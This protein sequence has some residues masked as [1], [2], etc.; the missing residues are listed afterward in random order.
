MLEEMSIKNVDII[1]R[2][3]KE[4]QLKNKLLIERTKVDEL[5]FLLKSERDKVAQRETQLIIKNQ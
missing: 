5:M 3:N 4:N 2:E 1:D